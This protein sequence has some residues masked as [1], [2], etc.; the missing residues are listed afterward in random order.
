LAELTLL[1]R[2][3]VPEDVV[4]EGDPDG[5]AARI[6]RLQH[7]L[8]WA[9]AI[10]PE[11]EHIGLLDQ[12]LAT[13]TPEIDI[14]QWRRSVDPDVMGYL[15]RFER[16]CMKE[17]EKEKRD[18]RAQRSARNLDFAKDFPFSESPEEFLA[19]R[20]IPKKGPEPTTPDTK[21][22]GS[23][24]YTKAL[25]YLIRERNAEQ[26]EVD[27]DREMGLEAE[28]ELPALLASPAEKEELTGEQRMRIE[29]YFSSLESEICQIERTLREHMRT[30]P[31]NS[32]RHHGATGK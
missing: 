11:L 3:H 28:Q 8:G 17:K 6:K 16:D 23:L 19:K 18:E 25:E 13:L 21:D 1:A 29:K 20:G 26:A 27:M 9:E 7:D 2:S 31:L 15:D 4:G 32:A 14:T 5:R 12:A 30:G 24:N 10:K 22:D